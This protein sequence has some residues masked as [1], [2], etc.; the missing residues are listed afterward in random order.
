M[1]ATLTDLVGQGVELP[2]AVEKWCMLFGFLV[3]GTLFT[4]AARWRSDSLT[5]VLARAR[6]V[7]CVGSHAGGTRRRCK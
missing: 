7:A 4:G 5:D 2:P 1:M 6:R 3:G